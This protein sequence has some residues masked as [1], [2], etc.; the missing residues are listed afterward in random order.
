ME[1]FAVVFYCRMGEH[2]KSLDRNLRGRSRRKGEKWGSLIRD[3]NDFLKCFASI[4][5]F[6][7][8]IVWGRASPGELWRKNKMTFETMKQCLSKGSVVLLHWSCS[9]VISIASPLLPP[10]F[11][12]YDVWLYTFLRHCN[13][14]PCNR[15]FVFF[16]GKL[17]GQQRSYIENKSVCRVAKENIVKK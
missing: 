8:P 3:K 16:H 4:F 12:I 15:L 6:F 1:L 14:F 11:T 9:S 5:N 2:I 17:N 7:R 13:P 10:P